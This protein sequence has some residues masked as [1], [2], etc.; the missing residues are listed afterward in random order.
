MLI[1]K[2]MALLTI[3]LCYIE[4]VNVEPS[5]LTTPRFNPRQCILYSVFSHCRFAASH[6]YQPERQI[7]SVKEKTQTS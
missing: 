4:S 1:I 7:E 3:R 5:N 2:D 6:M